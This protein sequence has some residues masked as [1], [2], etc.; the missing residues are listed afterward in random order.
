MSDDDRYHCPHCGAGTG[1]QGHDCAKRDAGGPA[2]FVGGV[3]ITIE[4]E[5]ARK[6]EREA[7]ARIADEVAREGQECVEGGE[8]CATRIRA[9]KTG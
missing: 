2:K 6:E 7:C 1:V 3:N 4:L 8:E 5:I 9:R